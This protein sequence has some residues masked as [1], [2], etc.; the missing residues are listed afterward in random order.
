MTSYK[1]IAGLCLRVHLQIL[2]IV[3]VLG[4]WINPEITNAQASYPSSSSPQ[5]PMIGPV[6]LPSTKGFW[7]RVQSMCQSDQGAKFSSA[8]ECEAL[9]K[10]CVIGQAIDQLKDK[11]DEIIH[12]LGRGLPGIGGTTPG[13]LACQ[14]EVEQ[15]MNQVNDPNSEGASLGQHVCTMLD[16]LPEILKKGIPYAGALEAACKTGSFVADLVECSA[17][18]YYCGKAIEAE[19]PVE[20]DECSDAPIVD[21]CGQS[22]A[23][24]DSGLRKQCESRLADSRFPI[25]QLGKCVAKCMEV[26]KKMPCDVGS[27]NAPNATVENTLCIAVTGCPYIRVGTWT[28]SDGKTHVDDNRK[29]YCGGDAYCLP[30]SQENKK[31]FSALFSHPYCRCL[32]GNRDDCSKIG[33]PTPPA[34]S[35]DPVVDPPTKPLACSTGQQKCQISVGRQFNALNTGSTSNG[36]VCCASPPGCRSVSE[37]GGCASFTPGAGG[38][39]DPITVPPVV[40]PPVVSPPV[41]NPPKGVPTNPPKTEPP[42][43]V[44]LPLPSP[45]SKP[46]PEPPKGS[47]PPVVIVPIP[48]TDPPPPLPTQ[49]DGKVTQCGAGVCPPPKFPNHCNCT[50]TLVNNSQWLPLCGEPPTQPKPGEPGGNCNK[51]CKFDAKS[52]YCQCCNPPL[53]FNTVTRSCQ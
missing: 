5:P 32:R 11:G 20:L 41:V 48:K 42:R 31:H 26:S 14:K 33:R 27:C 36:E 2:A 52:G 25:T 22:A 16:C 18:Y 51:G 7:G 12:G 40:G 28:G 4:G 35:S 47:K 43:G 46:K 45:P 53:E 21:M 10:K 38:G 24:D 30:P 19:K 3:L 34:P 6:K 49:C 23:K 29:S 15:F 39:V 37:G 9:C 8:P 13:V 17:N 50:L 1:T 44:P